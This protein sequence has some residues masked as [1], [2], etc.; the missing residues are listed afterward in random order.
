MLTNGANMFQKNA[1]NTPL[2]NAN[3]QPQAFSNFT[4]SDAL[5]MILH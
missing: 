4:Q 1:A 5:N 2:A 3:F